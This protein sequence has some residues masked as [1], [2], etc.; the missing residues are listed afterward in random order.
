MQTRIS[1]FKS[2][3]S[4]VIFW[5]CC[6]TGNLAFSQSDDEDPTLY[7]LSDEVFLDAETDLFIAEGDVEISFNG[8]MLFAKKVIYNLETE[9]ITIDG[10]FELK[11]AEG[12]STTYGKFADLSPDLSEGVVEAVEY[13]VEN[14][15][16]LKADQL[17]RTPDGNSNFRVVRASTCKVCI[18]SE[19]PLWE[20]VASSAIH[21]DNAKTVTYRNAKLL[22]RGFPVAFVPW[23]RVPDPSVK[24]ADGFLYPRLRFNSILGNQVILP[25]FKTLGTRADLTLIPNIPVGPSGNTT[26]RSS[27]IEARYRQ[28]FNQGYTEIHSA[29]SE[30]TLQPDATRGYVFAIGEFSTGSNAQ[31]R[32]SLQGASDKEYLGT[33]NFYQTPRSTFK[34]DP[35]SFKVDRLSNSLSFQKE[36]ASASFAINFDQ[37]APLLEDTHVYDTANSKFSAHWKQSLQASDIPGEVQISAAANTYINEFG[38]TNERKVDIVRSTVNLSWKNTQ[39]LSNGLVLDSS[40]GT[41]MDVYDISDDASYAQHQDGQSYVGNTTLS[42]PSEY[43]VLENYKVNFNPSLSFTAF[44]LADFNIP[45]FADTNIDT[46]DPFNSANLAQYFR[47][48][49]NQNFNHDIAHT[50][51]KVPISTTIL[52]NYTLNLGATRDIL[53]S[54]DNAYQLGDGLTYD[55]TFSH[56]NEIVTYSYGNTFSQTGNRIREYAKF[57]LPIQSIELSGDYLQQNENQIFYKTDE[58]ELWSLSLSSDFENFGSAELKT[59]LNVI[60]PDESVS[61]AK[62]K[63][64]GSPWWDASLFTEYNRASSQVTQR[65]FEISRTFENQMKLYYK[66]DEKLETYERFGLGVAYENECLQINADMSQYENKTTSLGRIEEFTFVIRLGSFGGGGLNQCS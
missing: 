10:P 19:V 35:F 63:Y 58:R 65:T 26:N 41:F 49:S 13:V 53:L 29:L 4:V 47:I 17:E 46:R 37:F 51:L 24:R 30:D 31:L 7:I 43:N 42:W 16:R 38:T 45:N 66:S 36:M 48:D 9:W 27:T 18:S 60:D 5:M 25:Y 56:D 59:I 14:A 12:K 40:I 44:N 11:D 6:F 61:S 8:S 22:I 54:A 57:R 50:T 33:Y 34:N 39:N 1:H 32:Y 21:D 64:T 55:A 52:D 28:I 23:V 15:L 2:V 3:L 20:L 62:L